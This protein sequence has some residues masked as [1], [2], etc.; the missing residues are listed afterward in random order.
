MTANPV[1][2]KSQTQEINKLAT[3]VL[4]VFARL[5][6]DNILELYSGSS[7]VKPW[8]VRG[9]HDSGLLSFSLIPSGGY[10]YLAKFEVLWTDISLQ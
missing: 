1:T 10:R 3:T 9:Y 8:E 4:T 2:T 5:Y 6:T 7:W